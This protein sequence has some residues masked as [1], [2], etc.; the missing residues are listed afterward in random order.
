MKNGEKVNS[1]DD[2]TMRIIL[3]PLIED[4]LRRFDEYNKQPH[5]YS[6][7]FI[8]RIRSLFRNAE[9]RSTIC[10]AAIWGRRAIVCIMVVASVVLASCALIKPLREKIA[11]AIVEWYEEYVAIYFEDDSA[12]NKMREPHYIPEGYETVSDFALEDYRAIRYV[13][14]AG[15]I[16]TFNC[17]LNAGNLTH[18]DQEWH[19]VDSITIGITEGLYFIDT[20][21]KDHM[22][23]WAI[24]GFVYSVIGDLSKDEFIKIAESVE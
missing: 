10:V 15:A 3:Q 24:D 18:F 20:A 16:I 9:I 11:G 2:A 7:E 8:Q 17:E 23:S 1:Y 19:E 14:E 22:I 21:G 13:N 4:E 6:A 5:E 12:H